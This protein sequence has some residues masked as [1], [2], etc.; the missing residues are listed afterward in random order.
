MRAYMHGVEL[1]GGAARMESPVNW[2]KVKNDKIA[3]LAEAL[4]ALF[5]YW[6]EVTLRSL[7]VFSCVPYFL[8]QGK[9]RL[10][11]LNLSYDSFF[12]VHKRSITPIQGLNEICGAPLIKF[13]FLRNGV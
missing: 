6:I 5:I 7:G 11:D 8:I 12:R 13:P 10:I 4:N 2:G 3:S 9:W 1:R